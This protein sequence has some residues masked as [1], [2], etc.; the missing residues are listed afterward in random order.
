[1]K[2]Q[3]GSLTQK[4]SLEEFKLDS[5]DNH[6]IESEEFLHVETSQS[7][8]KVIEPPKKKQKCNTMKTSQNPLTNTTNTTNTT[9]DSHVSNEEDESEKKRCSQRNDNISEDDERVIEQLMFKHCESVEQQNIHSLSCSNNFNSKIEMKLKSLKRDE[10]RHQR[11]VQKLADVQ[12]DEVYLLCTLF[13]YSFTLISI[14]CCSQKKPRTEISHNVVSRKKMMIG[15]RK[16]LRV[17]KISTNLA[18]HSVRNTL[19]IESPHFFSNVAL[20]F[21]MFTIKY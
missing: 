10:K 11:F 21:V 7:D 19:H 16:M 17:V 12:K 2:P 3:K 4:R 6:E 8:L 20:N 15:K 5:D 13:D 18:L 14:L 9:N 1:L